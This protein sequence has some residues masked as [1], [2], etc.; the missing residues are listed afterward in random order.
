MKI[1][2][3]GYS[4][5]GKSTLC[6]ILSEHYGISKLHLDSVQ[7]ADNWEVRPQ[8]IKYDEVEKFLDANDEWVI[9]G[10]YSLLLKE[11]RI[12]EADLII[13]MDFNRFN[14][15]YR[16][17]RRY[18]KYRN[19]SREDIG[20]NCN[21]KID[22]EFMAWILWDGRTS[23]KKRNYSDICEKYRDKLVVIRNQKELDLFVDTLK[24]RAI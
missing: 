4:G 8:A 18:L 7:F 21:E 14:C 20:A 10:N 15:L 1:S 19:T 3:I 12:E 13:F 24:K 9:D 6:R 16:C 23:E 22:S 2:I 11:R 17:F 5:S